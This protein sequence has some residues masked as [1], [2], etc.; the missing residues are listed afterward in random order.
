MFLFF[1]ICPIKGVFFKRRYGFSNCS[2]C[3]SKVDSIQTHLRVFGL[4]PGQQVQNGLHISNLVRKQLHEDLVPSHLETQ[5]I[6]IDVCICDVCI[7]DVYIYMIAG[8]A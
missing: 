7:C 2:F 8:D 4:L 1:F 5:R 3:R 6:G